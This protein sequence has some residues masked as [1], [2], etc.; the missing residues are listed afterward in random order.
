MR[1]FA[2]NPYWVGVLSFHNPCESPGRRLVTF[3]L[4]LPGL[5]VDCEAA[6][7]HEIAGALLF[8]TAEVELNKRQIVISAAGIEKRF[9]NI[10]RAVGDDSNG[11]AILGWNAPDVGNLIT[12]PA[13]NS[14]APP[15][16]PFQND[17]D[18]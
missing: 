2:P 3:K 12:Q 8:Y 5:F 13:G 4:D 17:L 15:G 11:T 9:A 1:L 7:Y 10:D 14:H 16:F 6:A 18:H